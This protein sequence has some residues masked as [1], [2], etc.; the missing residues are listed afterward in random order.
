MKNMTITKDSSNS[1]GGDNPS[2][3]GVGA[4]IRSDLTGNGAVTSYSTK[5]DV[6]GASE[7]SEWSDYEAENH[8][9]L[10]KK[11]PVDLFCLTG[12]SDCNG[13]VLCVKVKKSMY[14]EPWTVE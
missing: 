1:K 3:Y 13:R 14:A 11:G 10:A 7:S 8:L 12:N 9:R 2:F 6:S 4:A 5:G